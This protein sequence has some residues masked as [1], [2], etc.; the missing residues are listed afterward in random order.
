MLVH[1][2]PEVDVSP[3]AF[4]PKGHGIDRERERRIELRP[5][6]IVAKESPEPPKPSPPFV[7]IKGFPE[8]VTP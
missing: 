8:F 7:G 6:R 5:V 4:P 1:V 3:Q 2:A